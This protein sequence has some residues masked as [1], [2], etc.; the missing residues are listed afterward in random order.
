MIADAHAVA[1]AGGD[2]GGCPPHPES[3]S[4]KE[5]T[6]N[7][8]KDVAGRIFG[9]KSGLGVKYAIVAAN[10]DTDVLYRCCP[11][12]FRPFSR[13]VSD[14]IAPILGSAGR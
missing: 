13:E 4:G 7:H 1:S 11:E 8:P 2:R 12:G 5:S 9:S 10:M 14:R 6:G 3:L